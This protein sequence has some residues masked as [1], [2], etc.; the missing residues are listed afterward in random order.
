[1]NR[2]MSGNA[3]QSVRTKIAQHISSGGVSSRPTSL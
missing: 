2:L 1:M 3:V